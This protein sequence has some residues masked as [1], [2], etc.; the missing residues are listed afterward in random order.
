MRLDKNPTKPKTRILTT[1]NDAVRLL[2]NLYRHGADRTSGPRVQALRRIMV[3]NYHRD[4]AGHLCRRT[5]EK[6][7]GPGP[8]LPP[9]SRA[10][11]SPYDT[12]ARYARHGHIISWKALSAHLT[13]TCAPDG[14][15]VI[16][17]VATTAATTHDSRVLPG[18]HTRLARRGLLPGE[19]LA[20]AGYTFLPHLEQATREHQVTVSGPVRSNPTR[21]HRQ[22][23]GFARDDFHIDYDQQQV[24]CPPGQVSVGRHGPY[25]TSSPTAGP[26][27]VARFTKSQCRPCPARTQC[28][29]TAD[30]VRTVGF[31][32]R[33]LRD[34]QLRIRTEQ[35]TPEWKAR[36]AVRSGVE[37][38][39]N[40]FAHGHG[41]RHWRYRGQGKAH[42]QHVLTAIAVNIERLSKLP[43]DETPMPRRST[44][45][46]NYLDQRAIPRP[47]SW[48]T[49]G[50]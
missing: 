27:I 12:S 8:G 46:Q 5:A 17:D 21:Q 28:T 31:P 20:D 23:G 24:T 42:I 22:N 7:G 30:N 14:P 18:I 19:H 4:T 38:T 6:E 29:T 36:Y 35:Q 40:E 2:A 47:K 1:G 34:L 32:P 37:G 39:V 49:L 13:E 16:T 3:Q 41:M 48:R 10:V 11:V 45:F 15:N 9:S 25:P 26:L 33:E 44:A 50:S 43:P